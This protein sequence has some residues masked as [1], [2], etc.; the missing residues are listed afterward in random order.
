MTA[1]THITKRDREQGAL[2]FAAAVPA[3]L[4]QAVDAAAPRW[5]ARI[6]N[7]CILA[8]REAVQYEL[9]SEVRR[10]LAEVTRRSEYALGTAIR[11][12]QA[13]GTIAKSS[14][15]ERNNA[16][17]PTPIEIIGARDM[18]RAEIYRMVDGISPEQFEE[19]LAKAR[20]NGDL[21]RRGLL[22][23]LG[24]A[25]GQINGT[26]SRKE[27]AEQ[28]RAFAAQGL[29][30]G[31]IAQRMDLARN[32]VSTIARD[33]N[34]TFPADTAGRTVKADSSRIVRE[35]VRSLEDLL[36][37]LPLVR[38]SDLDPT[39]AAEWTASLTQSLRTLNRFNHKIKEAV[40]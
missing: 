29:N 25:R 19:G 4:A 22:R 17:L 35:T 12:G 36:M 9:S 8:H 40:Q 38:F 3:R 21:T 23:V 18:V 15:N 39:E 7:Q 5:V 33:F 11:Q 27:R 13:L 31:E 10:T 2:E 14:Q 34:I 28:I 24:T 26:P 1:L 6:R 16:N 20:A 30:R 37:G 32:T